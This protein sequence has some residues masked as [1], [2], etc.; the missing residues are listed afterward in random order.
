MPWLTQ[1]GSTANSFTLAGIG[2]HAILCDEYKKVSLLA[3]LAS[4][5]YYCL[6]LCSIHYNYCSESLVVLVHTVA[7]M[8]PS[9]KPLAE[10]SEVLHLGM[11]FTL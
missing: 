1:M 4:I 5:E 2:G 3:H 11:F 6:R 8:A 7:A 10:N 9:K